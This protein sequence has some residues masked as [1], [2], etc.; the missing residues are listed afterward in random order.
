MTTWHANH[1]YVNGIHWLRNCPTCQ[2][3]IVKT[4][5]DNEQ[6]DTALPLSRDNQ[7]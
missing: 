2:A 6:A 4:E 1:L 7:P 3:M 5:G